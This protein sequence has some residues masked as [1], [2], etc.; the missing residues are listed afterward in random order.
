M[1][2]I[3]RGKTFAHS[4][5][6]HA[7]MVRAVEADEGAI[8]RCAILALL[9]TLS[10]MVMAADAG[11]DGRISFDIPQQRADL[12]LTQFADQADLTLIFPF[13]EAREKTANRLVGDYPLE[14]AVEILLAGTGFNPT[15]SNRVV[16]N[17]ATDN[18]S[19]PGGKEMTVKKNA[20]LVAFLAAIFSVG[21]GAQ[22]EAENTASSVLEEVIVTAQRRQENLQ[23][24][25]LAIT[26]FTQAALDRM[27]ANGID[28]ID[29]LTPG[30]EFGM[31]F[32]SGRASGSEDRYNL[33]G[34][35]ARYSVR[36]FE[37]RGEWARLSR[38]SGFTIPDGS[39]YYVQLAY[40]NREWRGQL[41]L[42]DVLGRFEP[43]IRW[44]EVRNAGTASR[45]QLALGL[46]Y[47]LFE[48][49]P[50]KIAYEI[51]DGA[52]NDNRFVLQFAYGF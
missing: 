50:L 7:G 46:N 15:F 20:G 4:S 33:T 3:V 25:S 22:E 6:Q 28:R 36:G 21:A 23:N 48:S 42:R 31:S 26:A 5:K 18:Q 29:L 45:D 37:F 9:M 43:V 30:L 24:I 44:G 49:A 51:K 19:E 47:W 38:R 1:F 41:G 16:L 39:G 40:R 13:D 2:K 34:L 32:L 10:T 17:I 11:Q 35:D 52:D 12:A 8:L 27:G 14:E